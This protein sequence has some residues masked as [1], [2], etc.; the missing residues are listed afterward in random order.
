MLIKH[1][2]NKS[3][4]HFLKEKKNKNLMR[5]GAPTAFDT[6]FIDS[7]EAIYSIDFIETNVKTIITPLKIALIQYIQTVDTTNSPQLSGNLK[8]AFDNIIDTQEIKN[9][10]A[11]AARAAT[12]AGAGAGAG[13][14][15]AD[16]EQYKG[17]YVTN[18]NII[19]KVEHFLKN[20]NIQEYINDSFV[21]ID[22][23]ANNNDIKTNVDNLTDDYISGN[24]ISV[25]AGDIDIGVAEYRLIKD[26]NDDLCK[27]IK[28][29]LKQT[30]HIVPPP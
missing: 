14:G 3:S 7:F 8:R 25:V 21:K 19:E 13:A 22:F 30:L 2:K 6:Q 1:K 23:I 5:G 18:E 4:E 29:I 16:I 27:E 11:T 28:D 15:A 24:N 20:N 17:T 26:K 9:L 12:A 10:F